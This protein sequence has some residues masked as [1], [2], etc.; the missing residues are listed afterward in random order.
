[1][2]FEDDK[3]EGVKAETNAQNAFELATA[4]RKGM[5]DAAKAQKAEK[6]DILAD[7]TSLLE[8]SKVTKKDTEEDKAADSKTLEATLKSCKIKATEWAERTKTRELELEA[9]HKAIEILSKVSG[10]RTEAP[11][12]PVPPPSPL[13]A[14]EA[15][16]LQLG[17]SDPKMRAVNLLRAQARVTHSAALDRLAQEVAAHLTG[18]FDEV[19]Q[20][21]QKM[22]FRL[23]AEQKDE[24]DHK[25]WCD[26]EL[27]KTNTS[28]INKENKIEELTAK[29]DSATAKIQKLAEDIKEATAMVSAI[30]AHV[31]KA[32]EIRE[33]GKKEN[34][35]ALKDA[36]DAQ[37]AVS[38]AIAV[39]DTFYKESGMVEKADWE[40]LQAP[41]DLPAQPE[42][43]DASYTGVSDPT[44]QPGGIITL[45]KEVSS[46]FASM[47]ADTKAQEASDQE[48]YDKEMQDCSIEKARRA[49]ES[50]MKSQEQKR[51]QDKVQ[52]LEEQKKHVSDELSSVVQ[53]LKDLEPACVSGDSTYEDRKAA[54]TKEIEALRQ[55]QMILEG[56]FREKEGAGAP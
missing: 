54:R 41:V 21:I 47:E 45:M 23:M 13:E 29:I 30:D 37:K 43:W 11:E 42:T 16:F 44:A 27:E 9:M 18:P 14:D 50:E 39:L 51:L 17:G 33:I 12:N 1:M 10:V 56:A 25:N 3:L 38:D 4:S 49:K 34:A 5:S 36:Q 26:L 7:V 35:L 28:K 19:N 48:E 40:L 53:Y 55:A 20:M 24:D 6:E 22:I 31:A 15:S 8:E 2:N 52:S 32:T 46:D